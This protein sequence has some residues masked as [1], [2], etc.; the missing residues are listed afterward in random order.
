MKKEDISIE[1]VF[2]GIPKFV[3]AYS[4]C[5]EKKASEILKL[6]DIKRER[7]RRYCILQD[8]IKAT[9]RFII[10]EEGLP[11]L[12]EMYDLIDEKIHL[13]MIIFTEYDDV[14]V[15][16]FINILTKSNTINISP[17]NKF[18]IKLDDTKNEIKDLWD[19]NLTKYQLDVKKLKT[20]YEWDIIN[21]GKHSK[22]KISDILVIDPGYILWCII[23]LDHFAIS[24]TFFLMKK[25]FRHSSLWIK[26][27]EINLIKIL[28]IGKWEVS[29]FHEYDD[30]NN[31]NW[32][33]SRF[34]DGFEGDIDTWNH[35]NQ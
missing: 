30:D 32:E 5:F 23:N 22:K 27:I 33:D 28:I 3:L 25:S 35:Y 26:A 8:E 9:A 19:H 7:G 21:W 34:Y 16:G 1:D 17:T 6:E 10:E 20:Y 24:Y 31:G 29:T 4:K 15:N 13:S 18:Y 2:F 12:F 11:A 14:F